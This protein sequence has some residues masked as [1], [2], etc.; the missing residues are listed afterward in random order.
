MYF[1][2]L[3]LTLQ[4]YWTQ[5]GCLLTQPYDVE[6]GA[7][8][9]NPATFLRSLGPEPFN[10]AYVEPSRRPTDGRYGDNPI[11]LQ[12]Y[13]QFQVI[14]KP[15]PDDI[16]DLY[17][18]SLAAIGILPQDHDIRLVH[19]DWESPTLGAW[20]LGWEVW[21]DGME[22]TQFTYFQQVG[23]IELAPIPGE[24]TYGLERIC[25]FLQQ[26]ESVYDLQYNEQFTYGDVFHQNEVLGSRHN[27]EQADVDLHFDLFAKFETEC[28]RLCQLGNPVAA[29]DYCLKAS[30]TFNLLDARGA[31]SV[32]ERQNYILRVRQLARAVSEAWV[33][34]R[35]ALGLP[36]LARQAVASDETPAA[37]LVA[38]TAA[39][40]AERAP[41]LIEL[42]LEE[43]PAQVFA[44][45]QRQLPGLFEKHFG[46]T[47]LEPEDVKFY[48]TPRR[49]AVSVGS[50]RTRQ[51]DRRL[52]LRGPPLKIA[53]GD[54][55]EW[56]K[57]AHGF[58]RK[59]N[60]DVD[61]LEVREF[62]GAEY[63]YAEVDQ[64]G[65]SA[66]E[67][68]AEAIPAFFN[69]IHWYKTMRWT[70]GQDSFV[71]PVRWLVAL[72]GEQIVPVQFA[73]VASSKHTFG[74]RFLAP[75]PVEVAADRQ[76]YLEVLR[77]N[78]VLADQHERA[79][80]I[81]RE[82]VEGTTER[83]LEWAVDEG[84]LTQV[85]NLVEFPVPVFC[86]FDPDFLEIP[87][88]VLISEMREH[89]KYLALR[90]PDGSLANAFVS[91]SNMICADPA[92]IR[93]GYEK[94]LRSRFQDA[95]FF[96]SEDRKKKLADH[97][98]MLARIV[99]QQ[100]LGTVGDKVERMGQL[101]TWI[102]S[103]E[104]LAAKTPQAEAVETIARLCKAD[105]VTHMVGEFP[106]LQGEMGRYYALGEGL[107][108]LVAD[109]I[110][111]HYRPRGLD[112]ECPATDEAAVVALADRIDTLVG[113][114]A[115]G[116]VP[117]SS[118][119]P[120]ALRRACLTSLAIIV[121]R[122]F[123]LDLRQLFRASLRT[124]GEAVAEDARAALLDQLLG[125]ALTRAKGLLRDQPR[126]DI[127]GGFSHDTIDAV[128]QA[129]IPWT[130]VCDLVQRLQ[131]VTEFRQRDDFG[132]VAATFKRCNN[133]LD[134][135]TPP[136]ELDPAALT[137]AAETALL[138]A[139]EQA[140]VEIAEHLAARE[141]VAAFAA[142]GP[143]RETVDTFFDAVLVNDPDPAVRA[144]RH[145]LLQRVVTL[146]TRMADFSA[147]QTPGS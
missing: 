14:L 5:R 43:M 10:A 35:E 9:F 15:S 33:A 100:G 32:T 88:P 90:R 18:G 76:Q 129:S 7:G 95:R 82:I 124:Y 79:D 52:E 93:S 51:A 30:H 81:R 139:V 113:I 135:E 3:I 132:D 1:Q 46:P 92:V 138:A 89:Q 29:V 53:K 105:L 122:G 127:P 63:L 141:Y 120:F 107:P 65:K 96:L 137:H 145:A 27:F 16:L 144:N 112:D 111:D 103:V 140:G 75:G 55:G 125:F 48:L 25:M 50:I 91:V 62:N 28:G 39:T 61:Q 12:H 102:G 47:D 110:R 34:D 64:P 41:L 86:E 6:T 128:V 83:G 38:E 119:D 4:N 106:E 66:A 84:L 87:E 71:R 23:G 134:D 42:G 45:L 74:H 56:T 133:I 40:D 97:A 22:V 37:P 2:D 44:P 68:L 146:V 108:E 142:I 101:A 126:P 80:Q 109:G 17:F 123:H 20:G 72:L 59:S 67:V 31:I 115:I 19:D 13:F 78:H 98:E 117:T 136:A 118:A 116:K 143:L 21:V 99:F 131:A 73:G 70:T 121:N 49:I 60:L 77:R 85:S 58:A 114:F 11:R 94:V 57:A 36:L 104:G 26:V 147:I 8:T 130:D 69:A 54:N 24:I